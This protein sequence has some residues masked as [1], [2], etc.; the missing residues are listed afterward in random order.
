MNRF[1]HLVLAIVAMGLCSCGSGSDRGGAAAPAGRQALDVGPLSLYARDGT[2][3]KF[4]ASNGVLLVTFGG[5]L[6]A[7]SATCTADG[8]TL[9]RDPKSDGFVCPKDASRYARD[10][11][12]SSGKARDPLAHYPMSVNA[13]GHVIVDT[14]RR[15]VQSDWS[16]PEGYLVTGR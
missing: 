13:A 12:A 5:R 2:V 16:R 11:Q 8:A 10:G 4:A 7:M 15:L 14:G 1:G 3:D 6:T 9:A